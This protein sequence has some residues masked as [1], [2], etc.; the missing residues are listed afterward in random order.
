MTDLDDAAPLPARPAPPR[1]DIWISEVLVS[2]FRNI[3]DVRVPLERGT[4]FLVGENNAGKSSFLLAV[5]TACGVRRATPDDLH[6]TSETIELCDCRPHHPLGGRRVRGG[7]GTAIERE[8]WC[9]AR[10]RRVDRDTH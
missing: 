2:N 10:A 1:A 6:R 8:L 9:R 7:R 4:T 3:L 5:A